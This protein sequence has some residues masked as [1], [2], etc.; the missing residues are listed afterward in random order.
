VVRALLAF[1]VMFVA[2]FLWPGAGPVYDFLAAPLM[3]A[4]PQGTRMIAT[5]RLPLR[6]CYG[7]HV[8]HLAMTKSRIFGLLV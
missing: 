5:A 4:L 1:L 6:Q 3:N 2:I 8:A 7:G